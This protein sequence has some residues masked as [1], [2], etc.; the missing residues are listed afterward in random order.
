MI[1]AHKEIISASQTYIILYLGIVSTG[2]LTIPM[3]LYRYAQQNM[4]ISLLLGSF[5]GYLMVL[6]ISF[7]RKYFPEK[8]MGEIIIQLLGKT[9][10]HVS[11]FLII[12][13]FAFEEIYILKE[14]QLYISDVFYQFTSPFIIIGFM[15]LVCA[16]AVKNGIEVIAR[17]AQLILPFILFVCF[18][19]FFLLLP[20]IQFQN[21]FPILEKG[22]IPPLKGAV[23]PMVWYSEFFW[24]TFCLGSLTETPKKIIK[25]GFLCVTAITVTILLTF[26]AD[27]G[28]LGLY[29]GLTLYP[30]SLAE[31]Y[32]QVGTFVERTSAFF[33]SIWVLG[34]FIKLAYLS[35]IIIRN[36]G[37]LL[38]MTEDRLLILPIFII[39]F[40]ISLRIF[41][42]TASLFQTGNFLIVVAMSCSNIA[43]PALFFLV[44]CLRLKI[45]KKMVLKK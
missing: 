2:I 45:N 35:F 11:L 26:I 8:N 13:F 24:M 31:R 15:I 12:C 7:F 34:V 21:L 43:F 9:L 1:M 29:T 10:G 20:D 23:L 3:P 40:W 39:C 27:L 16:Y 41:N 4:W 5:I 14:Y 36:S 32:I 18:G 19:I 6:L 44:A 33:M 25:S 30:I 42:S 17:C 38:H 28:I 37:K 22:L